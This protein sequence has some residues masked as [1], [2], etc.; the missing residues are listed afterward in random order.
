MTQ[1]FPRGHNFFIGITSCETKTNLYYI[2]WNAIDAKFDT[3]EPKR[4]NDLSTM[5]GRVSLIV[6]IFKICRWE[7]TITAANTAF[8]LVP[9]VKLVTPNNH[10]VQWVSDG[11]IKEFN[12][13]VSETSMVAM[14]GII[15]ARLG[16]VEWGRRIE[17]TKAIKIDIL[18]YMV[19]QY[20]M[21]LGPTSIRRQ[22]K[23]KILR[24]VR[25]GL[26]ELHSAGYAHCDLCL[27][28]VFY[29]DSS[30]RVFLGDLEYLTPLDAAHPAKNI[31]LPP[32]S[33]TFVVPQTA[34]GCDELGYSFM[35]Y[36]LESI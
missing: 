10:I 4:E 6:N 8:H 29:D 15:E 32:G 17:G 36:E 31:R 34:Q 24:E 13:N 22:F 20:Y 5:Y 23:D 9:V 27:D 3:G 19:R 14:A 21:R 28:N 30:D 12:A 11:L 18:G 16:H 35:W 7:I 25:L 26:N 2:T 33:V 1:L